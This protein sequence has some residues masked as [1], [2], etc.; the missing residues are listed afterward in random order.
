MVALRQKLTSTAGAQ[1]RNEDWS[2]CTYLYLRVCTNTEDKGQGN[3]RTA[4]LLNVLYN[5]N[6]IGYS[7]S[8][9]RSLV[10]RVSEMG[11]STKREKLL[12]STNPKNHL[13]EE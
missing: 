4:L 1:I 13:K 8:G 6:V 11:K 10:L 2:G 5:C 7:Y 9:K 3:L 12:I